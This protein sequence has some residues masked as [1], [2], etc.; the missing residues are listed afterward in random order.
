MAVS[1]TPGPSLYLLHRV[2]IALREKLSFVLLFPVFPPPPWRLP[3]TILRD[4]RE[5]SSCLVNRV[6]RAIITEKTLSKSRD[7]LSERIAIRLTKTIVPQNVARRR[8]FCDRE[9]KQPRP[10]EKS[11]EWYFR[12]HRGIWSLDDRGENESYH[13]VY[14]KRVTEGER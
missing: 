1:A 7:E 12:G 8:T 11:L 13:Y 10:W 2:I 5:A 6:E 4:G 14:R 9:D 3:E